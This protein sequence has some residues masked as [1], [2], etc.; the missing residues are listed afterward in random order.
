MVRSL[1]AGYALHVLELEHEDVVLGRH[2]QEA[3]IHLQLD[4]LGVEVDLE[5]GLTLLGIVHYQLALALYLLL[6][7]ILLLNLFVLWILFVVCVASA[8]GGDVAVA[9]VEAWRPEGHLGIDLRA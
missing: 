4:D 9:V 7:E 3:V 6:R 1:D 2:Q 5:H 8:H